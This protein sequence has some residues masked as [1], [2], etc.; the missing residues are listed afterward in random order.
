MLP[1][2][3]GQDLKVWAYGPQT[4]LSA[5]LGATPTSSDITAT[6]PQDRPGSRNSVIAYDGGKGAWPALFGT[7]RPRPRTK[8]W[9]SVPIQAF[10]PDVASFLLPRQ[11]TVMPAWRRPSAHASAK[12]D[13]HRGEAEAIVEPVRSRDKKSC[14]A[15]ST[16]QHLP[17]PPLIAAAQ[18][19]DQEIARSPEPG[20][21]HSSNRCLVDPH[22]PQS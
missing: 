5:N 3:T 12:L 14:V 2:A 4:G 19:D 20:V 10:H 6:T 11:T 18:A 13:R 16:A 8:G 1:D 9:I 22:P 21:D 15:S 17:S 7:A